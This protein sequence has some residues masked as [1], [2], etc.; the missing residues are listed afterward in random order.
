MRFPAVV[1]PSLAKRVRDASAVTPTE[2]SRERQVVSLAYGNLKIEN[3]R[4]TRTQVEAAV[5]ESQKK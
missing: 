2:E 3:D 5:R 1:D 4:I